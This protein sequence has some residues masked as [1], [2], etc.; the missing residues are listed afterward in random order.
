MFILQFNEVP[1]F[2]F[3]CILVLNNLALADKVWFLGS[4]L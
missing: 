2:F 1:P 3:Q 4:T